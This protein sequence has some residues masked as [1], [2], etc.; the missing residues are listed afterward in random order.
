MI[1]IRSN[2]HFSFA[3]PTPYFLVSNK[4]A[5]KDDPGSSNGKQTPIYDI[6]NVEVAEEEDSFVL[7]MDLPG[8]KEEDVSI[9]ESS[10]EL[11]I[12]ALRRKS[13]DKGPVKFHRKFSLDK[14]SVDPTEI[15]ATLEDGVLTVKIPKRPTPKTLDITP[16]SSDPPEESVGDVFFRLDMPGVK[17]TDLKV[18]VTGDELFISAVRKKGSSSSEIK[19][20]FTIDE[21]KMDA[22][23]VQAFL[24]DGVLTLAAPMKKEANE[25][26]TKTTVA[27]RSFAV[28][29]DAH[30]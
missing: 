18:K 1:L 20:I 15:K 21:E 5:R 19:R 27:K 2:P 7:S 16:R 29:K 26:K 13:G 23:N 12:E 6:R 28:N 24:S 9:V 8:V 10:F 11:E 25:D 3:G 17:L 30:N 14:K 4:R 22:A